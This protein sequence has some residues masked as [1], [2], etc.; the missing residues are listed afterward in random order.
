MD[1]T[2]GKIIDYDVLI[3]NYKHMIN[4]LEFD[5]MRSAGKAK[6]NS[7]HLHSMHYLLDLAE[8]KVKKQPAPIKK[9]G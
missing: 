8:Q 5:S 1:N 6:M 7:Q 2:T 9:E 4:L 3:H